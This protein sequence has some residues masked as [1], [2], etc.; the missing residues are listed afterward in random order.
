MAAWKKD[1]PDSSLKLQRRMLERGMIDKLPWEDYLSPKA[2]FVD[3][4][5]AEAA[6]WAEEQ[7]TNTL[8]VRPVDYVATREGYFEDIDGQ[9]VKK[10]IEGYT[11]N[12]EQNASTLWQRVQKAKGE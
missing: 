4:A 8:D 5:A 12:A 10:P 7:R 2:D 6:K 11:Q 1:N 9:Q 3:E